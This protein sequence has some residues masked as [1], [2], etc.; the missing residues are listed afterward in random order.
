MSASFTF[1]RL[2]NSRD[3]KITTRAAQVRHSGA[4]LDRYTDISAG[5]LRSFNSKRNGVSGGACGT[6]GR[7]A[8]LCKE[9]SVRL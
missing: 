5:R 4:K 1:K 2:T 9:E 8:S 6:C 3:D 7:R